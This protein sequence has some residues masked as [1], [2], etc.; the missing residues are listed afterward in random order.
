MTQAVN[1]TDY[2]QAM[3]PVKRFKNLFLLLILLSLLFQTN[4]FVLLEF[5]H[6]LESSPS[7]PPP[8]ADDD[9]GETTAEAPKRISATSPAGEAYLHAMEWL[10]PITKFA[11]MVCGLLLAISLLFAALLSLTANGRGTP[12]LIGAFFWSL[13]L[14]AML[15]PWQQVYAASVACG[16]MFNASEL[17]RARDLF[18]VG[19][20]T[21]QDQ[22]FF[23]GRFLAYPAAV[24]AVWWIVA[25]KFAGG[26]RRLTTVEARP[27]S[28]GM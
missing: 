20:Q 28:V 3:K 14:L 19:A 8:K 4:S 10:L 12:Q 23:Y 7:A 6:A 27:T 22:L 9:S 21:F 24:L 2:V 1:L 26:Y 11:S 25:I 5:T 16:V 13:I 15:I 17:M 18:H